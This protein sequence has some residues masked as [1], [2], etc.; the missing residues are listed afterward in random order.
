[1][2]EEGRER[3][4]GERTSS[5]KLALIFSVLGQLCVRETVRA[6]IA[7]QCTHNE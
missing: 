2:C 1:M 3:G 5:V 6:R 7:E 4:K